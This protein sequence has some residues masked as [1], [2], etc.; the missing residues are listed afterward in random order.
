MSFSVVIPA[1]N[2]AKQISRTLEAF[3]EIAKKITVEIIV[4]D[5]GS[6]DETSNKVRE[7]SDFLPLS[8]LRNESNFGAAYSRNL[9][10]E[11]AKNEI[12]VFNDSDDVSNLERFYIHQSHLSDPNVISFVSSIK[13]YGD[14]EVPFKLRDLQNQTSLA[15]DYARHILHGENLGQLG[16][17]HL[18]SSTMALKKSYFLELGG[19]DSSFRRNEDVDLVIRGLENNALISTSSKICVLR[20]VELK[21]HQSGDSNLVGELMLL[22]KY[23]PKYL[24]K[25]EMSSSKFWFMARA[26]YFEK[27]SLSAVKH[28]FLSFIFSPSRLFRSLLTKIPRRIHHDFMNS[29]SLTWR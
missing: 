27:R 4:I 12:I 2:A 1:F 14:R 16:P 28:L 29:W 18:P 15:S 7:Y 10:V 24:T 11:R 23:A 6:N 25:R 8:Y 21:V 20:Y 26:D 3:V 5:D 17:C 19:F 9:G 22:Q 13:K